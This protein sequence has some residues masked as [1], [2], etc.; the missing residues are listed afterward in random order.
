MLQDT[1]EASATPSLR[2]HSAGRTRERPQLLQ[3]PEHHQ[4]LLLLR[5]RHCC[6]WMLLSH[7]C[8]ANVSHLLNPYGANQHRCL[9]QHLLPGG[10]LQLLQP[11]LLLL[12]LLHHEL[13]HPLVPQ[14]QLALRPHL[15]L[16]LLRLVRPAAW[17]LL[18]LPLSL[19]GA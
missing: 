17:L 13:Q 14:Q 15:Q 7:P 19:V 8:C 5:L 4:Q 10:L 16:L 12:P 11:V 6:C 9:H 1:I 18:Q 3:L 2:V